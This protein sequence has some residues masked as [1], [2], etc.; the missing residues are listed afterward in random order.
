MKLKV[1]Y[2]YTYFVAI[3]RSQTELQILKAKF[4][5]SNS[6]PQEVLLA[7]FLISKYIP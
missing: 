2:K 1:L 6:A 7:F 4:K 3:K 5:S